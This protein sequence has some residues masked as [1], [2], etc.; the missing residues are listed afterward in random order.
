MR[1]YSKASVTM[2]SSSC[3]KDGDFI[4]QTP[5][6]SCEPTAPTRPCIQPI[7]TREPHRRWHCSCRCA[8][9]CAILSCWHF[10][11]HFRCLGSLSILNRDAL[12]IQKITGRSLHCLAIQVVVVAA[13]LHPL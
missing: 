11:L 6:S 8:L 2:S 1:R 3:V 7:V 12:R 4:I 13:T 10:C 5:S 9:W